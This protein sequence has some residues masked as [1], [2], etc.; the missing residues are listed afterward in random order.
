MN[1]LLIIESPNKIKTI[2][3]Y[4]H[5]KDFAVIATVGHIRDLSSRSLGFNEKTLEP[6]WII[7]KKA[8]GIKG[9][10]REAII[11]EIKELA[12]KAKEIYLATDPDREGEAISW[13]VWS[14]LNKE[15]QKKCKRITF[16]EITEEAIQKALE[17]P[18]DIDMLWVESQFAR[19]ILDRL[20]GFKVSKAVKQKTGGHSAGRV[21]SVALKMIYDREKEIEK[22]VSKKW[23]TVNPVTENDEQLNL[24]KVSSK[25]KN[26]NYEKIESEAE[27]SG[28]NFYDEDS[29]KKVVDS[30]KDKYKVYA[31]DEPKQFKSN[32]REPYK[33]STL[34]QDGISKLGWNVAKVTSV[35][36]KLYEGVKLNKDYVALISYPRTDSVRI[37]DTFKEKLKKFII[38]TYGEKYY[39][40][41]KLVN[42]GS[43]EKNVQN[44]HEAIRVIDVNIAPESIKGKVKPEEY[45]LYNLIWCRTVAAFMKA[46]IYETTIIRIINNDNRFYT[47]SR[48][49]KF[50]GFKKVYMDENEPK[51]REAKVLKKVGS[52]IIIKNVEINEHNTQPPA[53]FNQASLIKELDNAGVGRPSTYR[54][55]AD[56]ALE[57]G[58]ATMESR[59]YHMTH[60]G[61]HVIEF[62]IK[63][64]N[65]ITDV[66]FTSKVEEQLDEIANGEID[67]K[68][69]I[70]E[71][72]PIL[73]KELD[74]I[75]KVKVQGNKVGRKCPKCGS[76][77]VY[78]Y[79]YKTKS[80]FIGCENYPE[81]NYAEFPNSWQPIVLDKKCP[82]CGHD[83]VIRQA[84][85]GKRLF[86]GCTNYPKCK[87][88]SKEDIK[89]TLTTI[90]P[91]K[92]P[93]NFKLPEDKQKV[94]TKDIKISIKP[95][96]SKKKVK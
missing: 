14:I 26:L 88:I 61:Y 67:W 28:V 49:L 21:Q 35:A 18:R 30:L 53:R 72:Q 95:K 89:D 39:E 74:A 32:P 31:V 7:P 69:P 81:C 46:A 86:V 70:Q 91:S 80:E 1:K 43:N 48:A 20:V 52:E 24:R 25:L 23:W 73:K 56:M 11:K 47:Y 51:T 9:Q 12:D 44:A 62:L 84:K 37:S 93:P 76:D 63:Y 64:F 4:I 45:A 27:G 79:S 90:D 50:D 38:K 41:H 13:H 92:L 17:K 54:S 8:K 42:K 78:R 2:Q 29:A 68:Q 66:G 57:R 71:F 85:R 82:E 40:E 15:D 36:Q 3:K 83:L 34:Q 22:F 19:R 65:F 87:Y 75:K 6:Q 59:A 60:L 10:S 58:Y 94:E 33:T 16:N 96:T 55:M 5:N 77:L